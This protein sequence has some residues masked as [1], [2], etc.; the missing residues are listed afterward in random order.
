ML[1]Q[2]VKQAIDI[3][4]ERMAALFAQKPD[5]AL[6]VYL[7]NILHVTGKT[8]CEYLQILDK[9]LSHIE[10]I[11]FQVNAAKSTWCA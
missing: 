8:F 4:Q 6:R 1:L 7:D 11:G 9:I 5:V 10:N 2:G 3:F